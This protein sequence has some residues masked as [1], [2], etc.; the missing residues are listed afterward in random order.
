M[1]PTAGSLTL[2]GTVK[3]SSGMSASS[4][5]DVSARWGPL[6]GTDSVAP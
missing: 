6:D 1:G 2:Q 5:E 3:S 4:R